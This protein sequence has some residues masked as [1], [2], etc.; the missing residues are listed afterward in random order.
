MVA[1]LVAAGVAVGVGAAG[2]YWGNRHKPPAL[3]PELAENADDVQTITDQINAYYQQAH[4]TLAG[5]TRN[6]PALT[7]RTAGDYA[8]ARDASLELADQYGDLAPEFADVARDGARDL[9][10]AG[11]MNQQQAAADRARR[12]ALS[13]A[14][15]AGAGR[16]LML[17]RRGISENP[18]AGHGESALAGGLAA[19]GASDAAERERMRGE[20]VRMG[21]IP[22]ALDVMELP[23]EQQTRA[24]ML[25][26]EEGNAW[27]RGAGRFAGIHQGVQNLGRGATDQY[28]RASDFHYD[29]WDAQVAKYN[30]D[31][32][33]ARSQV[34]DFVDIGTKVF[35]AG[36]GKSTAPTPNPH[37]RNG[38][39]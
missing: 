14:D 37:V 29:V 31:R 33:R 36:T 20:S 26:D 32:A 38:F 18:A 34:S 21:A 28:G 17:A 11:N 6:L 12:A 4:P 9:R 22:L 24:A 30:A 16:R 2:S 7:D 27:A 39:G 19:L 5:F 1:P 8:D 10:R 3:P 23:S 15:D 35:S 13:G 25:G